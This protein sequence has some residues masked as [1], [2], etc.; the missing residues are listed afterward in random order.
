MPM[1]RSG[2]AFVSS[3]KFLPSQLAYVFED[4]E[5]KQNLS[6]LVRLLVILVG[7]LAIFSVVF[8]MIMVY[9]GLHRVGE[10]SEQRA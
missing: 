2:G 9:E 7:S 5:V 1:P 8:R 6:A 3:V 4:R 10:W